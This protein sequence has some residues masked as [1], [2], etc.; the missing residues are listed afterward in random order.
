MHKSK[1]TEINESSISTRILSFI[2]LG[3]GESVRDIEHSFY[4]NGIDS[5]DNKKHN[6]SLTITLVNYRTDTNRVIKITKERN[7]N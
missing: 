2:G 5:L 7:D 3:D 4:K 1:Y 6:E